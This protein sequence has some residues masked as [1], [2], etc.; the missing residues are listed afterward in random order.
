MTVDTQTGGDPVVT[1]DGLSKS[2]PGP[3]SVAAL[4]PCSFVIGRG[5]FVS[6]T[7]PSGSGKTTLLSVLGLLDP[8]TAGRYVLDGMDVAG[9]SD[10]ER[11]GVRAR[12]IGFVFQAF[13]LIGYRTLVENVELG[14]IYQG[15][16]KRE[17][18]ARAAAVIE[19]V[20]LGSRQHGLCSQLSGGEKQRVAIAR[21][22]IREPALV[23][24]DEPTGN[25]DSAN[26][27]VVLTMLDRLHAVG[28]TVVVVTHDPVVAAR[29]HRHLQISDG[30][31]NEHSATMS[32]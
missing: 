26:G 9:L 28:L 8:P 20:G 5:E 15:V 17:R 7:G 2:F 10:N 6:I 16:S 11:A 19:H 30:V 1:V 23:L 31:L 22:L 21:T 3:P 32:G 25:L 24:C 18:R 4:K 12:Q 27:N 13:H 29:A 14:L